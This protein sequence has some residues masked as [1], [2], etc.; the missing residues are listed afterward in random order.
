M[1]TTS[2]GWRS[3]AR[4]AGVVSGSTAR[5]VANV[6]D[7]DLLISRSKP[8]W[9]APAAAFI[10]VRMVLAVGVIGATGALADSMYIVTENP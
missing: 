6:A 8:T 10:L 4:G 1:T 3:R 9:V 2:M 7:I 5:G